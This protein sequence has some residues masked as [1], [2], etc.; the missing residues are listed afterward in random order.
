MLSG[1]WGLPL[2]G[3]EIL[4]SPACREFSLLRPFALQAVI[5]RLCLDCSP[6]KI[7]AILTQLD[8]LLLSTLGVPSEQTASGWGGGAIVCSHGNLS[9]KS[10]TAV[11]LREIPKQRWRPSGQE[12]VLAAAASAK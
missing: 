4:S 6:T 10:C 3:G 12:S 5:Y 8:G 7:N 11:V 9:T 1:S 2:G